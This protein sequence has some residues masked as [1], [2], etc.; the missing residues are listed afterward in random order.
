MV[1]VLAVLESA[2]GLWQCTTRGATV[3]NWARSEDY[4]FRA[5]G[6]FVCPN[7]F[8][9]FLIVS[10]GLLLGYAVIARLDKRAVEQ[11]V[12]VRLLLIYAALMALVGII[13]SFSRA[14]TEGLS[15]QQS[16]AEFD[17]MF[18]ST[19][20]GIFQASRT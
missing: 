8:A 6:T 17:T 15:A 13:A 20:E 1:A 2:Y 12:L 3:L 19:I 5:G 4:Q 18:D 14:L 10:L 9:T 16:Q 11:G 7:N